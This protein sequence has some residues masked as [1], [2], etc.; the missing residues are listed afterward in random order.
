MLTD[1]TNYCAHWSLVLISTIIC[2]QTKLNPGWHNSSAHLVVRQRWWEPQWT[3]TIITQPSHIY[4]DIYWTISLAER[5]AGEALECGLMMWVGCL[6]CLWDINIDIAPLM[7]SLILSASRLMI[8]S[9]NIDISTTLPPPPPS[10]NKYEV[11]SSSAT[12]WSECGLDGVKLAEWIIFTL[13]PSV[14]TIICSNCIR[15]DQADYEDT[16]HIWLYDLHSIQDRPQ[17]GRY[18]IYSTL[19][20]PTALR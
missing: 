3:S 8:S 16:Q 10:S 17:P 20:T 19:S 7:I 18:F 12:K 14:I 15:S 1:N 9:V 6:C 4:L 11:R 13:C 5:T 2:L